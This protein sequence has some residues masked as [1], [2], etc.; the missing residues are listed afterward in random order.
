MSLSE[1][2]ADS[3]VES[4]EWESDYREC[5]SEEEDW[6]NS[7][8]T[9]DDITNPNED[10]DPL[11]QEVNTL[12]VPLRKEHFHEGL[13]Y[14][15]TLKEKKINTMLIMVMHAK[16]FFV[17]RLFFARGSARKTYHEGLV[18][19]EIKFSDV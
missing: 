1:P 14:A 10:E 13:I 19:K 9:S 6:Y 12:P 15:M 11:Y 18:D 7:S 16:K 2:E 4:E 5:K 8:D 17:Y 3:P